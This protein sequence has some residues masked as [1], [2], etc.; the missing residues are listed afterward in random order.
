MPAY[1]ISQVTVTDR[2]KFEEY[3][4]RTRAVAS[5]YGARPVVVGS[6]PRM[7][8]GDADGHQMVFVIEF[9]DMAKLNAWHGSDDYGELVA[10]REAGSR[11]RMVAYEAMSLPPA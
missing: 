4:A 2:E 6:Q 9:D 5:R 3:L 7:L 8:S 10:L 1:M 11:Q